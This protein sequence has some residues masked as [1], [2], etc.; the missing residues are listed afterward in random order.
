VPEGRASTTRGG[1]C[2]NSRWSG[3]PGSRGRT[4]HERVSLSRLRVIQKQ[5]GGSDFP[6]IAYSMHVRAIVTFITSEA[7]NLRRISRVRDGDQGI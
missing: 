5:I 4:I 2:P 1:G 6:F 7:G 3:T